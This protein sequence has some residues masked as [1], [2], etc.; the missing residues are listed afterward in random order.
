MNFDK[1]FSSLTE[2]QKHT[3]IKRHSSTKE[4]N[5]YFINKNFEK[6]EDQTLIGEYECNK[7]TCF[8]NIK[9]D[10]F[11]Q[12]KTL[13]SILDEYE[14]NYYLPDK[15]GCV[16]ISSVDDSKDKSIFLNNKNSRN[17]YCIYLDKKSLLRDIENKKF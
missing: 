5:P 3:L 11:P 7:R 6:F 8:D 12:S 16:Y 4:V 1:K 2:E 13:K 17:N 14:K 15:H 10:L 9:T